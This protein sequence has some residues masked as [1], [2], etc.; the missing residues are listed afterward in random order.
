MPD[1]RSLLVHLDTGSQAAARLA[2]GIAL[3]KRFDATLDVM[4]AVTPATLAVGWAGA[5]ESAALL[6]E[7][8]QQ[9]RDEARAAFDAA[10]AGA[11]V[12]MGWHESA[13]GLPVAA[14]IEAALTRDLV[15]LGQRNPAE[16]WS[17]ILPPDFVESV[18]IGSGQGTL[19][20]PYTG[21]PAGFG[22][23]ALVAWKPTRE[24]GR[25]LRAALPFLQRAKVVDL[26]AWGED[27]VATVAAAEAH[28]G[29]HGVSCRVHRQG[30]A[31]DPVGEA[32]L[33]QA[34]DFG[35]DLLVM[36]LYGHSRAREWVLGGAS[37][38]LL[39]SMTLPVLMAH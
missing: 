26:V 29:R 14:T 7:L 28:L 21:A 2:A 9:R 30:V 5:A 20:L 32:L 23:R 27:G 39:Q 10:A 24:A 1:I 13:A 38:T 16:R 19:V 6:A 37:R 12:P 3:A 35:S 18:V 36:G 34:A 11:G 17:A 15:L 31:P 8:D 25:A 33:S 22:E 4:F